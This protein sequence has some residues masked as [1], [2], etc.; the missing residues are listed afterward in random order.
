[1]RMNLTFDHVNAFKAAV[2]R[3]LKSRTGIDFRIAIDGKPDGTLFVK[4]IFN[5]ELDID[6]YKNGKALGISDIA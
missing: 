3:C 5:Y 4:R 2:K 6:I 1:M